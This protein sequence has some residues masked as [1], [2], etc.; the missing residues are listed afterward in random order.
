MRRLLTTNDEIYVEAS[1]F[2]GQTLWGSDGDGYLMSR[3]YIDYRLNEALGK[4]RSERDHADKTQPI[5]P[6]D[7]EHDI[8]LGRHK[9]VDF[10]GDLWLA[11]A[12]NHGHAS[13]IHRYGADGPHYDSLPAYTL[14][15]TGHGPLDEAFLIA[16]YSG[17]LVDEEPDDE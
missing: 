7:C 6:H 17:L 15:G 2:G 3:R 14:D 11:P 4:F 1:D 5:Y 16:K 8:F 13:V 10:D 12:W 9:G